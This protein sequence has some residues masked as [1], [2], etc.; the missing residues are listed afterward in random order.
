LDIRLQQI[1]N[2]IF[3]GGPAFGADSLKGESP[4]VTALRYLIKIPFLDYE[5]VSFSFKQ[6]NS[7]KNPGI[8]GS[9]GVSNLWGRTLL[10]RS[11]SPDFGPGAAYQL[12]LVG[13]PHGKLGFSLKP[14][15]PFIAVSSEHGVRAPSIYVQ[16]EYT[17]KNTLSANTSRALWPGA[18]ITL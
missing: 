17:Q 11:E 16:D 9:T 18:S 2:A 13:Q 10:F 8:V 5:K 6:D 4:I 15:F 7:S 1:S 14:S 12:G 3:G